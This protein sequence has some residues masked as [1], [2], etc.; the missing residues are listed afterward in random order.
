MP[1]NIGPPKRLGIFIESIKRKIFAPKKDLPV[2]G[3]PWNNKFNLQ[4]VIY[5]HEVGIGILTRSKTTK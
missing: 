2:P 4:N 5:L 3:G 1:T